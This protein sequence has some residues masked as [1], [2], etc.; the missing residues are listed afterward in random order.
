MR[1]QDG[2]LCGCAMAALMVGACEPAGR[3]TPKPARTSPTVIT[4]STSKA[5]AATKSEPVKPPTPAPLP[6]DFVWEHARSNRMEPETRIE[7]VHEGSDP[8]EWAR[9]QSFWTLESKPLNARR[10]ASLVG[11]S[12]LH[13]AALVLTTQPVKVVKIKVPLGLDDPTPHIP[14]ANPPTV[15]KWELGKQLFFDDSYLQPASAAKVAC[16]SCHN[17]TKSFA[18]LLPPFRNSG[19]LN[20]PALVNGVFN[21]YQFWDGRAS[22]LEEV[23]ARALEDERE[24]AKPEPSASRHVWSGMVKR[25]RENP[26]YQE[27]FQ[28]VFGTDPTQDAVGKALATYLR[29]ILSGNAVQDEA[30]HARK[31]RGGKVLE[32]RDYEKVLD[33]ATVKFFEREPAQKAE[34][35]KDLEAGYNLFRGKARCI[36]CH[37]GANFTD[38]SF[39]NIGIGDSSREPAPGKET[40]RFAVLPVGLKDARMIGAYK[41]PSL[42]A[43]SNIGYYYHDGS[44]IDL[45]FVVTDHVRDVRINPYLDAELRDDRDPSRVRNFGLD[46]RDVEL[47]VLFL[48]ALNGT[49]IDPVV[50]ERKK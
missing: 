14:L 31:A 22:A 18:S 50:V 34:L 30:Q 38:N 32:P 40:G 8:K 33:D 37:S 6:A 3:Y 12:P 44:R 10:P 1:H 45:L 11:L 26:P 43:L 28:K 15:A 7:F 23:V 36:L 47:L 24:P 2:L 48:K 4:P 5:P 9:L 17:P 46:G 21:S 27:R 25:L 41:T 42:R 20:T 16:A 29:T 49:A 19:N 39:H 35:A 13:A